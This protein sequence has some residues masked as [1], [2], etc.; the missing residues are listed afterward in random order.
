MGGADAIPGGL[1]L[2]C[3]SEPVVLSGERRLAILRYRAP[4]P[5]DVDRLET[6]VD[7]L[8]AAGAEAQGLLRVAAD[9]P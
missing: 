9:G 8:T 1:A 2:T 6:R 5:V 4:G 3:A 7:V